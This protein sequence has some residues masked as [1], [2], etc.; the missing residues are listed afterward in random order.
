MSRKWK[1][2]YKN[3]LVL[4]GRKLSVC[5]E[6]STYTMNVPTCFVPINAMPSASAVEYAVFGFI[7][8]NFYYGKFVNHVIR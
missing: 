4:V 8:L 5:C 6:L 3:V 1:K 7:E 2:C